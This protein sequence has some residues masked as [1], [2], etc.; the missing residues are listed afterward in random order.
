MTLTL[1]NLGEVDVSFEA[2]ILIEA[3]KEYLACWSTYFEGYCSPL[4]YRMDG[5]DDCVGP[6]E[7][8]G[9]NYIPE[10]VTVVLLPLAVMGLAGYYRKR[11]TR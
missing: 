11:R 3:G 4:L 8:Y 1:R 10:P 7:A 9:L 6:G 5:A 2:C